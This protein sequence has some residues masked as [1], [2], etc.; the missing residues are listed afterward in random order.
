MIVNYLLLFGILIRLSNSS[1]SFDF[2]IMIFYC[3]MESKLRMTLRSWESE[4]PS[5]P[6]T[7]RLWRRCVLICLREPRT[8]S[9][10]NLRWRD[11]SECPPRS[12]ESPPVRHLAVKV[13]TNICKLNLCLRQVRPS[14]FLGWLNCIKAFILAG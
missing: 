3:R 8:R 7:S 13:S 12:S 9:S 1:T 2:Q 6:A 10:M 14:Y 4:L 5:T 11:Q